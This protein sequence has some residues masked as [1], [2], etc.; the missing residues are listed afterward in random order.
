MILGVIAAA[1]GVLYD[2]TVSVSS[3]YSYAIPERVA[4]I[5]GLTI[6]LAAILIGGFTFVAGAIFF[7]GGEL[8]ERLAPKS[9]AAAKPSSPADA[10]SYEQQY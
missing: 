4:N 9:A 1:I 7:T 6:Q 5:Q 10:L 3:G 2:P 8:L